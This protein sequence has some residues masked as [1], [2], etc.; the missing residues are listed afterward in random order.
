MKVVS[1]QGSKTKTSSEIDLFDGLVL[2]DEAKARASER[3][4]EFLVEQVLSSVAEKKSPIQGEGWKQTLSKD[5]KAEKQSEGVT[6]E[7]NMELT[8][9][10]L[11]S[12]DYKTTDRGIEI[13]IFGSEAWKA[14]GHNHFSAAS[15]QA[16]APKRRF[17]PG[18]D[19][20]FK[21]DIER[22]VDEIIAEEI[23]KEESVKKSDLKDIESK[24][25]FFAFFREKLPGY[26]NAEISKAILTNKKLFDIVS[27][28]DLE[29][30]LDG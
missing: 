15:A 11:D 6:A 13:G 30:Y 16:T 26:S 7:P 21:A 27:D 14:D 17:L 25:Q 12:L 18:E 9:A 1:A 20:K 4:G 5:Y 3:I 2:S 8:G 10:M 28:L 23:M 29:E 24:A 19:Q 22:G